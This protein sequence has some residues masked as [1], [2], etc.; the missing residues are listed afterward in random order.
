MM[1]SIALDEGLAF[2]YPGD[3]DEKKLKVMID[4]LVESLVQ[5]A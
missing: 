5:T 1:T 3:G 4:A 2:F